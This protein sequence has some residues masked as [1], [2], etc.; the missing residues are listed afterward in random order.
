MMSLLLAPGLPDSLRQQ[1]WLMRGKRFS[2]W[3]RSR[4]AHSAVRRGGRSAGSFWSIRQ[5]SVCWVRKA[6]DIWRGK[7]AWEQQDLTGKMKMIGLR[8]GQK[9]MLIFPRE[10]SE[11]GCAGWGCVFFQLSAGQSAAAI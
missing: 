6:P 11:I 4:K 9:R 2:F 7:I 1:K 5:N 10:K 8:N 3:I